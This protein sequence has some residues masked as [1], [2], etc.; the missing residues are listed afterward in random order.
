MPWLIKD[1]DVPLSEHL[2][3]VHVPR[4]GG[5]SL[6]QHFEVQEK[7]MQGRSLWGKLGMAYFFHRY[8]VLEASNFPV[9][10]RENLIAL[11]FFLTS[12]S[13][14]CFTDIIQDETVLLELL[15]TSLILF[16]LPAFIFTA[17]VIGRTEWVRRTFL[18][19]VHY[20]LGRF[21][22]S[23]EWCTGSNIHGYMMHLTGQKLLALQYVTPHQMEHMNS[24]AIVRNPYSRM[25][26]VYLYNR[27]GSMESFSHF[28]KAW[29]KIMRYYRERKE[30]DEWYTPCHCIP[31]F[32]FTH[33]DGKQIVQ[34]VVKQ[35]ELKFLKRKGDSQRAI[36][37]DSTVA[38]LPKAVR[39]ALLGMPHANARKSSKHWWDYYDQETLDITYE[40]YKS[41][42]EIFGYSPCLDKR[43]DLRSPHTSTSH[44]SN[45][46]KLVLE[47][48][49]PLELMRRDSFHNNGERTSR[50]ETFESVRK[51][52]SA[53]RNGTTTTASTTSSTIRRGYSM[54][55]M[56]VIRTLGKR[57]DTKES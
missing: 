20:P 9:R 43:P 19:A 10:S 39:S 49:K 23:I 17:P 12:L 48:A 50:L 51:I 15:V 24:M 30:M 41:D 37:Q 40:L 28:V 1:P 42:F 52:Y 36:D 32:E 25:I 33:F 54:R 8:K 4:C 27:Y 5:T 7:S 14:Y 11:A 18:F 31:Q 16:I 45:P 13:L 3:F 21:M 47:K 34:S 56:A 38:D 57:K 6:T 53:S 26:S 2:F 55:T 35:E 22:E 46:E 44:D 29:Y